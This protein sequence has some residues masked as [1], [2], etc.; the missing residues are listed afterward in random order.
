MNL[1]DCKPGQ[2]VETLDTGYKGKLLAPVWNDWAWIIFEGDTIPM[3][4]RV[5]RLKAIEDPAP[6]EK[7]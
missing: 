3:T 5:A 4:Q 1:R 7:E 2:S 6:K